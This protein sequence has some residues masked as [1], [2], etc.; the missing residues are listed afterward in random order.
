MAET[1]QIDLYRAIEEMKEISARGGTFSLRFRKWNRDTRKGG[2][3][4]TIRAA[5]VRPRTA[6]EKI[7]HS[8]YK[9]FFTDTETGL[10]R[11]CWQPLIMEFNGRRT[12]LN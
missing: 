7:R 2:D 6:D 1:K 4:V 8:S 3:M 10:A 12:V 9:F 5:R 11:N